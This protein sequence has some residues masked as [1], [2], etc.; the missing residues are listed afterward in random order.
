MYHKK[1]VYFYEYNRRSP[2]NVWP[3]WTGA[4]HGDDLIAMFGIPF[5]HPENY[6]NITVSDEQDYSARVMWRIGNFTK[7]G[8]VTSLWKKLNVSSLEPQAL[9]FN[10][11]SIRGNKTLYTNVTTPSCMK[12]FQLMQ[13]SKKQNSTNQTLT[14]TSTT[15][16]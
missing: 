13:P 5:R 15:P 7:D 2:I 12:L 3:P 9:V 10:M 16:K 4:M 8:N 14:T 11:T 1:N 6:T